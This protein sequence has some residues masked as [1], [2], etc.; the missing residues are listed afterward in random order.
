[1]IDISIIMPVYNEEKYL[2]EAIDSILS[3][4][5]GNFEFIIIDDASTDDSLLIIKSYTD[6]RIRL[7]CHEYNVGNYPSRNEGLK[8]AV[9]KYICV[10]DADDVAYPQRLALQYAYL[11]VHSDVLAIGTNFDFSVPEMKRF[12]PSSYEQIMVGL[13]MDNRFL[14]SSLMIRTDI[15]KNCGGYDEKYVYS[16]DY[17][18][19]SRLALSGKIENL[20]NILMMYRWHESQISQSHKNEQ[21]AYA[22]EICQK[23]QIE[24]INRYRIAEQQAPDEWITGIPNI[25]RIIAL[26]TYAKYTKNILYEKLAEELLD[27]LLEN[28]INIIPS[29][30][31]ERSLCCLGCGFIYLLRNG[32]VEGEENEVLAELDRR[33]LALSMN[34]KEEQDI[35]LY[36]WIHYLTLRVGIPE[37]GSVSLFNKLN[38]I[39]MLDRLSSS[40]ITDKILLKD[41]RRIDDLGIFP[42]RTN[43]LLNGR[44]IVNVNHNKIDEIH[45]S[46]VTFVIP[47]RIDSSERQA[48]LDVV[49]EQLSYRERTKI[50]LLEADAGS[51]C[52]IPK[53][54][55]NVIHRFVKDDNPV[56]YRTKYL[57]ELLREADTS[58]VGI[59]DADVIVPDDQIDRSIADIREGK[60]VLSYPYDGCFN[61]CSMEDSFIFRNKRSVRFLSEKEYSDFVVHSVG[62]AFLV[63]RDIYIKAGG[64]NEHF[65]G[66]GM[67]DLER[68]KRMEI[69]GLPVSRVGGSLFHLF[70]SRY[71]NSRFY[72]PVLEKESRKEFLKVCGMLK[73]ELEQYVQTWKGVAEKY[74]NTF[75]ATCKISFSG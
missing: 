48:N 7:I 67:E 28:D 8:I 19:M 55:P 73:E 10:M 70:H 4:T 43:R 21:K 24:F 16:S 47:I 51:I 39:Q 25:G 61:F 57:N 22:Y 63:H 66:W 33:L 12:L 50:I 52:R 20:T 27:H 14:H 36:G 3:Q 56:F 41:I 45:D 30:G 64:E 49:L 34:W 1:M 35:S 2:H 74:E 31:Q 40:E 53:K 6:K 68:V 32:F 9:G 38:L 17:N 29:L 15:M 58:I 26:Y 65:Y 69:L 37:N 23:Y 13:L 11:E 5:F 44:D 62:G 75:G 54:C 59:W 42:E 46:I 18:L 60:A 72:N 71:E